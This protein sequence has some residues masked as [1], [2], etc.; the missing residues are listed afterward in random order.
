M[1]ASGTSRADDAEPEREPAPSERKEEPSAAA[2]PGGD[3]RSS[4]HGQHRLA[5]TITSTRHTLGPAGLD[6]ADVP[7]RVLAL[8]VDIIVLAIVGL[9]L[10]R[11]LGGTV[12]E[13]GALDDPG[14]QLDVGTFVAVMA[15]QLLVSLGYF[16]YLWTA[17]RATAGMRLLGIAVGRETD[18]A[19]LSPARAVV[20]WALLGIPALLATTAIQVP[21]LVGFLLTAV[22]S[23]WLAILLYSMARSDRLQG[24]HDH[25]AHSIVYRTRRAST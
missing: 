19:P 13:A 5:E 20:R 10:T 22:G 7:N 2:L 8:L 6:Y 15:L 14:G 25:Y 18:G 24:L 11:L 21:H 4:G 16:V 1:T 17:L 9:A 23:I 12:T 3:A